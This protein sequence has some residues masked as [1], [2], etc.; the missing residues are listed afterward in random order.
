MAISRKDALRRLSGL[1]PELEKH[2][3]KIATEPNCPAAEHWKYEIENFLELMEEMLPH[4]GH[5]TSK[6]WA[7]RIVLW[8][9]ALA[10]LWTG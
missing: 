8:R 10:E 9:Q 3:K 5:K 2:L 1:V 6:D 7:D 4:V